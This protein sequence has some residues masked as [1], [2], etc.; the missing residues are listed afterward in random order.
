M[1][2]LFAALAVLS[3][4]SAA[5]AAPEAAAPA[6][7]TKQQSKMV[8][9]N[10]DATGKKGDERKAFM[11]TCLSAAP[12]APAKELTPQ[13]TKMKACSAEGKGKKGAEYKAFMKT[14]LSAPKA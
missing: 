8:T 6:A 3:L 10:A 7:K 9:C 11:K 2:K 12:A 13:Q 5:Y 4:C 1:K 14:C